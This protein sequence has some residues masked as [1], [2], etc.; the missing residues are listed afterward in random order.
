MLRASDSAGSACPCQRDRLGQRLGAVDDEQ[1]DPRR[2]ALNEIVEQGLHRGSV[3]SRPFDQ[4]QRMLLAPPI[5]AGDQDHLVADVQIWIASRSSADRSEANHSRIFA[6]DSA[7]NYRR[8]RGAVARDRPDIAVRQA[9]RAA[10][11]P[12]RD[13]IWFIAHWVSKSS[14]WAAAQLGSTSSCL[15]SQ[16]RTRGRST[17]TRPP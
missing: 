7:T 9:H 13:S 12:G 4:A 1:P 16:L 6:L 14:S 15:P 17:P 8:L 5:N 10:E 3:L 2:V 11:L